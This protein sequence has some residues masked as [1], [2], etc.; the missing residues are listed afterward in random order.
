MNLR[1]QLHSVARRASRRVP[2][3]VREV[4]LALAAGTVDGPALLPGPPPGP[5]LVLAPHPDDETIGAGGAVARHV[6]AGDDV[7]VVVA[8]SG[9]RTSGGRGDVGATRESECV[10]ACQALGVE[11]PPVFLRIPDGGISAHVDQLALE[12]R[13]RAGGAAVVYAPSVLDPHRDHRAANVGLLRAELDAEVL[14]YE[15]WSPAPVDV[16]ID[17]GSVFARKEAALRCY[18]TALESVDY[19]RSSTG[20]A[21][22]RSAAGGM[23][24]A[25]YAEGFV[26]LS[27]AE[28]AVLVQRAG[29]LEL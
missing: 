22:Y 25:G 24:G 20:L 23:G 21:A 18:A 8:T 28:H 14:G 13:N 9:E 6:D 3:A 27:A 29:L 5:V 11:R 16:L 12:L 15:V 19:V 4:G 1:R 7:T 26:R 17:V 2:P 10:A